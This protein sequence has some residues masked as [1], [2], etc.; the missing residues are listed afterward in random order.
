MST[1]NVIHMS[2]AYRIR[3]PVE[4]NIG[5]DLRILLAEGTDVHSNR[6]QAYVRTVLKFSSSEILEAPLIPYNTFL[7]GIPSATILR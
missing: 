6:E 4:W 2:Q 5:A 3:R 1:I 7:L